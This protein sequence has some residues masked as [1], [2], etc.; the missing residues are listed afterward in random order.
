MGHDLGLSLMGVTRWQNQRTN[1]QT[2]CQSSGTTCTKRAPAIPV[3]VAAETEPAE[4]GSRRCLHW[5][6]GLPAKDSHSRARLVLA[7][8]GVSLRR[9][10][11]RATASAGFRGPVLLQHSTR[12]YREDLGGDRS[13]TE[14]HRLH[15]AVQWGAVST[16]QHSEGMY[17]QT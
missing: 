16:G 13:Q 2:P 7:V 3:T 1:Q 4:H 14:S 10:H 15:L 11:T 6:A 8:G 5:P 17:L 12:G 9:Q